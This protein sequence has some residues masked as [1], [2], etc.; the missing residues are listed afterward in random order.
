MKSSYVANLLH[1]DSSI[2]GD[3]IRG[4]AS[5]QHRAGVSAE[6]GAG[7]AVRQLAVVILAGGLVVVV[8]VAIGTSPPSAPITFTSSASAGTTILAF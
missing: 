4:D 2:R 3:A 7:R 6:R 5:G 1:I 8:S